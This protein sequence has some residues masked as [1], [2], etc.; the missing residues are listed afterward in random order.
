MT[1]Y[2]HRRSQGWMRLTACAQFCITVSGPLSTV[3]IVSNSL[4]FET[5][6]WTGQTDSATDRQRRGT[7]LVRGTNINHAYQQAAALVV[8]CRQT[9]V[10]CSWSVSWL[11]ADTADRQN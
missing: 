3:T 5:I 7:S 8:F 11:V 6:A 10:G 1:F 2:S 4:G 9:A